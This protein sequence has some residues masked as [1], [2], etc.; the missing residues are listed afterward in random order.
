MR[1]PTEVAATLNVCQSR[2][3][4]GCNLLLL[5][6]SLLVAAAAAVEAA[7]SGRPFLPISG[8]LLDHVLYHVVG[9]NSRRD[10]AGECKDLHLSSSTVRAQHIFPQ[11]YKP[12][13][14][15]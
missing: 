1:V 7:L 15:R 11:T 5:T 14:T 13:S 2:P 12:L 9:R 10:P 3:A 8:P 6:V 4:Q